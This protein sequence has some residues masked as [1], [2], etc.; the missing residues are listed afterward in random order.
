MCLEREMARVHK[1]QYQVL[2]VA[3]E[4]IR[5]GL[6]EDG[7]ISAPEREHRHAARAEV[8]L[9]AGVELDVRAIIVEQR[10]LRLLLS[11]ALEQRRVERVRFRRDAREQR[12]GHAL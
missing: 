5:A 1:V 2:Y 8:F 6:D 7:V 10:E 4:R 9:P 11:L 12:L 3:L